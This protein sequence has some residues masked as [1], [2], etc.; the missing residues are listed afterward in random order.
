LC[1]LER[2]ISEPPHDRQALQ[3]T[4]SPPRSVAPRPHQL[5][6]LSRLRRYLLRSPRHMRRSSL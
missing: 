3:A 2:N 5:T 6:L 4:V 1:A